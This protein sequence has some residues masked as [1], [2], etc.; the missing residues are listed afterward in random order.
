MDVIIPA[1]VKSLASA[2]SALRELGS[3]RKQ[4][5]G[6]ARALIG[7]LKDN[8][9]YLEMVARDGVDLG[10]VVMKLSVSEY[11]R[12]SHAGYNFN[13]LRR[14]RIAG[15]AS[16][17]GTELASWVGKET[18]DLVASIYDKINDI[19]IRYPHVSRGKKYRWT[20]RVHNIRKRIWLLLRHVRS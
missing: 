15:H 1:A 16:L 18:D 3:W 11:K 7:E 2:G 10:D 19:R 5:R 8:M 13:A 12:L 4:A 9:S 17:K 20:V 14:G 6:D